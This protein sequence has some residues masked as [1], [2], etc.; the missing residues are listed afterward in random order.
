MMSGFVSSGLDRF[1]AES[2]L[3]D[4]FGRRLTMAGVV[5]MSGGTTN[6][7]ARWCVIGTET[8]LGQRRG[9]ADVTFVAHPIPSQLPCHCTP[10]VVLASASLCHGSQ[11]DQD[12]TLVDD[13]WAFVKGRPSGQ[14]WCQVWC[15]GRRSGVVTWRSGGIGVCFGE[16]FWVVCRSLENPP[17]KS[18]DELECHRD[19][20][21]HSLLLCANCTY[22]RSYPTTY[23]PR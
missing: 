16:E 3:V 2:D 23:Q 15:Q 20:M 1:S 4:V 6:G 5:G 17:V 7:R 21:V 13:L 9:P 14:G 12:R 10:W 11:E 18:I 22:Y 19:S 8:G